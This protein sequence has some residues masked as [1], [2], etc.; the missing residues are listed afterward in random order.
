MS[1]VINNNLFLVKEHV[2]MFKAANNF[3]IYDPSTG[4]V[5]MECRE[6][7]LGFF[8][9]LL[10]FTDYKRMT[11]FDIQIRTPDGQRI[12]RIQ[13]GVSLFLSKIIVRDQDNN[14]IG[15][16]AQK[17]FS[18]GGKFDVLNKNEQMICQ[19]EGEWTGWD[20]KFK[21]DEKEFAHVS[22]KWAGLGKEMF[23]SADNYILK[24]STD[25]PENDDVRK[26]ILA[27]VMCID[28]VLKE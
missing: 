1:D 6:P 21:N 12:V 3:D 26:L 23:T 9:K 18:I 8:T 10:R 2:G 20:F 22:K 17:L 24:I 4:D 19:L 13:R 11:P 27:A 7:S 25:V 28:M 5:I 14:T 16:F 15:G